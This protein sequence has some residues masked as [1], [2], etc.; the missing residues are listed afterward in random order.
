[1]RCLIES[2]SVVGSASLDYISVGREQS[3]RGE[4]CIMAELRK[5]NI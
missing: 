4:E 1:M 5:T 2:V 3:K